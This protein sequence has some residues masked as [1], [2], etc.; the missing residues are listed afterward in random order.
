[1]QW[2]KTGPDDIKS[3]YPLYWEAIIKVGCHKEVC[4]EIGSDCLWKVIV[5]A[6]TLIR[7]SLFLY[8]AIP[9]VVII[10]TFVYLIQNAVFYGVPVLFE[11]GCYHFVKTL[12]SQYSASYWDIRWGKLWICCAYHQ[13]LSCYKDRLAEDDEYWF[14]IS[15]NWLKESVS[16]CVNSYL[17]F[18]IKKNLSVIES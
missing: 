5:Y 16:H 8:A 6:V 15:C 18:V 17:F 13:G 3:N 9:T 10:I 11:S 2:R 1:M 14:F 4:W 7:Y 12:D